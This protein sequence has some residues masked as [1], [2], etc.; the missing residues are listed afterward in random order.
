MKTI[1]VVIPTFNRQK[2][3]EE[4]IKSILKQNYNDFEIIVVDNGPSTDK[5][6]EIVTQLSKNDKRIKYIQ[7]K[8]KGLIFARNIGAKKAKGDI[9]HDF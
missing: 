2:N 9:Y 8:L 4:A 7:T 3:L 1:S 5:T 6:K